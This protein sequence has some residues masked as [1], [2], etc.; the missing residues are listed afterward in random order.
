MSRDVPGR[1]AVI[2]G[3]TFLAVGGSLV[4]VAC[5][6]ASALDGRFLGPCAPPLARLGFGLGGL[7]RLRL[8]GRAESLNALPD[9]AGGDLVILELLDRWEAWLLQIAI[10]RLAGQDV[11]RSANFCWLPKVSN[12]VVVAA[13]ASSGVAC[14]VMLLSVSIVKVVIVRVF[15][16]AGC[17]VMPWIT[18][19]GWKRKAILQLMAKGWRWRPESRHAK[20]FPC[21]PVP[22]EGCMS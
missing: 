9:A 17:A 6:A 20:E 4:L 21:F 22:G 7:F 5:L 19:H 15:C 16:S 13:A 12:G 11:A 10:S 3:T 14:A 8:D 2:S 1:G 18:L